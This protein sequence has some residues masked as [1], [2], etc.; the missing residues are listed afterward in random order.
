MLCVVLATASGA[1]AA[2]NWRS[3]SRA[4]VGLAPDPAT[5]REAVVQVYAARAV[6][7][8][9]YIGV[10]TWIAVKPSNASAFTVYEVN[11]WRLR[12]SGTSVQSSARPADG[13][14]FG[15]RPELLA[16]LRGDEVDGVI[17]RIKA[18]VDAYTYA[19]EYRVWPGPNSNTFTAFVLRDIP[20]LR[21]DLPATAIGK[22]YLGKSFIASTP[23]GTGYQ[24]S[25]LGLVGVLGGF[26]EGLELNLLGLTFGVDPESFSLKL[27]LAGRVD[28]WWA[29]L[30]GLSLACAR[31]GSRKLA[32]LRNSRR[33]E[34]RRAPRP[35]TSAR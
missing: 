19:G 11:G 32:H 21:V 8:R 10:H 18:A 29:I 26:E 5:T 24:L 3:A 6:R 15:N 35:R 27:P 22:D 23:S 9:G 31:G 14:W 33:E 12:R 34:K 30:L 2:Q 25:V 4:S 1:V 16:D 13:R 28:L 20:E 7:W 17:S